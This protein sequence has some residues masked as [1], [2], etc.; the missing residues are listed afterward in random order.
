[1]A[2]F[3]NVY[4]YVSDALR[5]DHVP[6]QL[7]EKGVIETLAPAGYTPISFSS[8]VTGRNPGG[9]DVRSFYDTL[10]TSNV[11]DLFDSHCYYDHPEDAMCRNVFGNYTTAREL[12]EMEPPFFHVER[13]LETHTPYGVIRHGNEIPE[14]RLEGSREENYRE[15][16]RRSYEHFLQHVEELKKRGVYEDTLVIFTSDHGEFLGEKK[17]FQTRWGHNHP[18]ARE[19]S[20]VPTIFHNHDLDAD[21]A[22]TIDIVPTAL[23]LIGREIP[24]EM[25]GVDLTEEQPGKGRTVMDVNVR[26]DIIAGCTW[27]YDEEWQPGLSRIKTDA[28]SV[29]KDLAAPL[30]QRLRGKDFLEKMRD[31]EEET[32]EGEL[33][34]VDV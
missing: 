28:A 11:F 24:E 23:S 34:H 8:L 17:L 4:I 5:Y 22:R 33:A 18:V 6:Q 19:I 7:E 25:Q 3:E 27:H 14:E 21:H 15:A 13:A 9:H 29:L 10:E 16:V 20:V 32:K 31:T 1:M 30:K 12:S 2:E 26:P